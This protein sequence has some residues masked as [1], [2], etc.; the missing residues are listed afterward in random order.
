[1]KELLPKNQK[2]APMPCRFRKANLKFWQ[3]QKEAR[4]IGQHPQPSKAQA[5]DL[6]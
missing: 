3:H 1:M 6:A 2:Y 4:K 5:V